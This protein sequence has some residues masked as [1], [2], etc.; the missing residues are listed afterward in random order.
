MIYLAD[1]NILLR[2]VHRADPRH[3]LVRAALRA[4]QEQGH[5]LKTTEKNLV[6]F[7]NVTTRPKDQ[8]GYGL[9]PVETGNLLSLVE[10]IFPVLPQS[11][12]IYPIWRHLVTTFSVR[13]V[14]VHDAHHVAAMQANNVTHI[15]TLNTK[16][17]K[18]YAPEGIVA[19]D[20]GDV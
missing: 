6:E 1:T 11:P 13:G 7:W 9:G 2:A 5:T 4:L 19:V 20:P 10:R 8:N 17:F 3:Q 16:D 14:Q 15:L 12:E 18:R